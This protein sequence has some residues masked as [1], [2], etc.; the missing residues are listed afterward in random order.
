MRQLP[1]CLVL[2]LLL[3]LGARAQMILQYDLP[4]DTGGEQFGWSVQGAGDVNGDGHDDLIAGAPNDGETGNGRG[5]VRVISG[6]DGSDLYL[7]RGD[8]DFEAFGFS[9]AGLGDVNGDG[10]DDV[11]VGS[12]FDFFAGVMVG[13]ADVYSGSDG[14]LLHAFHGVAQNDQFG[15]TVAGAG[16]VDGDGFDDVLV[17][18]YLGNGGGQDSGRV[19]VFSG[20][21]GA[22]LHS[23]DGLVANEWFGFAVAGAG[24]VDGD[25]H[26]DF[27]ASA[28]HASANGNLSGTVRVYSGFGG[29]L[30]HAI[31]GDD[32]DDQ[33]GR[34]LAGAGDLDGDGFD[35]I[36]IGS[37]TDDTVANNAG[38]VQVRS[39]FDAS[40]LYAFHG[41]A[42]GDQM[43]MSVSGGGD[44]DGDG[45]PDLVLGVHGYNLNG[46]NTGRVEIRSGH[47]GSLIQTLVGD[48]G[49]WFGFSV[50]IAGDVDADGFADL[51]V[52]AWFSIGTKGRTEVFTAPTL[53]VLE[54]RSRTGW[55]QFLDL[56]WMPAA[57]DPQAV[58]G[59]LVCSGG[60][61]GGQ[62][63][64]VASLA[65]D[66]RLLFGY[67]PLLVAI[68]APNPAATY[69]FG[70]DA[71]GMMVAPGISRQNPA[72]VGIK[73]YVQAF[74]IGPITASSSGLRL[75]ATP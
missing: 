11:V 5:S 72:F 67:L 43:G 15:Y 32:P 13:S 68:D 18:A 69:D 57:G 21:T 6:A 63:L 55:P 46:P 25:G 49:S 42:P 45:W 41:A 60:T 56:D 10:F 27:M 14:S 59:D 29:G 61:P 73:V 37:I 65:S 44:I 34:S 24:D 7:W 58:T 48:V 2:V 36:L 9:V 30:I 19:Q 40:L 74:E 22:V 70:F 33:L 71:L 66:D 53:P 51:V 12:P 4:G 23:I 75:Q 38:L 35:D 28:L 39:G 3:A 20:A 52:G 62:G 17:G 64:V 8:D 26:A 16:D 47:D 31:H 1:F 50:A 54:Y